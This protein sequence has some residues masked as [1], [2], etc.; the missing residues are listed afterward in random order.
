MQTIDLNQAKQNL[1]KLIEQTIQGDDIVITKGGQPL[2]RLVA[3]TN[4]NKKKR[5]FGGA[6][7]FI[8][9]A[10]DFDMPIEDFKEYM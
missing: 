3:F 1:P 6:K 7:E 8:R 5:Q 9:F 10:D 4:H 2:V